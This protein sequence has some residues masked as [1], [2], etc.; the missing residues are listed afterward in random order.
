MP[1]VSISGYKY[2]DADGNGRRASTLIKGSDPDVV[3]V[4][5]VSGS[6]ISQFFGKAPVGDV[7]LDGSPNTIL[8][9][10]IAAA[11]ALHASLMDQGFGG[12]H[13]G[14][15]T[16]DDFSTIAFDGLAGDQTGTDFDFY[17]AAQALGT[18]GSTNYTAGLTSAQ[19]LLSQW[20][21]RQ[22]NVI[23]LSDG[24][25]NTGD[26]VAVAQ[27]LKAAGYNVQAFGVG[28][29]A[30]KLPL[31][32][33][34]SDGSSFIFQTPD[35]LKAVLSGQLA[36]GVLNAVQYTEAGMA[37]V[38]LYVD[39]NANGSFDA[40]EPSAVS[41]S[42][43]SFTISAPNL[44]PGSYALREVVPAGYRQTEIPGQLIVD[45]T[46]STFTGFNFGNETAPVVGPNPVPTPVICDYLKFTPDTPFPRPT[47]P[48]MEK[49]YD[50]VDR[51]P[52]TLKPAFIADNK[53]GKAPS[54]T[55]WGQQH[56]LKSGQAQGRVLEVVDGTEDVNDYAAYVENYG[57]TLLDIYRRDPRA[58]ING[59]SMSLFNWGKEHFQKSGQAAGRLVDG[60]ADWGAIV[61]KNFD[62][63]TRWQDAQLVDPNL[64]AFAFGYRNQN[65]IKA[66]R[67]VQIGRDTQEKLTGEYVY[68]LGGNDVLTGTANDDLLVGGFGDDLICNG[69]GGSDTVFG[70]PGQ[71]VFTLRSGGTLNVRD[72]RK[73]SDF[74]KLGDGLTEAD[75]TKV[76]DGLNNCTLFKKGNDVLASVYG[77]NP[78]DWSFADESDGIKNVFIA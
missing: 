78:N 72:Y 73:G 29:G 57:T 37:G 46:T 45:G 5:D 34:D 71:D 22:G 67:G 16:F 52:L 7:N 23:F 14:L 31:D 41:G 54:Q 62:L 1:N 58:T 40:G 28:N 64:S 43:G 66:A 15:V 35:D 76:F 74:L 56:W 9:A 38:T 44:L 61:L 12:S 24:Q 25:P 55:L 75:V 53:A 50:Y 4:L 69:N 18:G 26:G 42:D 39:V 10:E 63:Y 77:T 49:Y 51:Y 2:L 13:L 11:G 36:G 33:V 59:G 68:A 19:Q 47:N 3:L 30:T 32:A 60:G 21:S 17:A 48:A 20:G 6:T 65:T 27:Q 8:D 70:G